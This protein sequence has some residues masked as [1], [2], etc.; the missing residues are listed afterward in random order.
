VQ[1]RVGIQIVELNPIR[2]EK[3]AKKGMWGKRES[4][5]QESHKNYPESR[6]RPGNNLGTGG[7]RFY[8]GVLEKTHLLGL[9]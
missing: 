8:R 9:R 7:E 1:N 2:E 3:P 5:Q 4:L 6:R